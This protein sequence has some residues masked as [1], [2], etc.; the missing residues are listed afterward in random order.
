MSGR[1]DA[2]EQGSMLPGIGGGSLARV[3]QLPFGMALVTAL[4]TAVI[5][6]PSHRAAPAPTHLAM[7]AQQQIEHCYSPTREVWLTFDDG[8][9][10]KQVN[11]NLDVLERERVRAIFFPIGSW[12]AH[13]HRLLRRMVGD[14]HLVGNH[15]HDHVDLARTGSAEGLWEIRH[16][17]PPGVASAH[18]LRPPFGAGAYTARVQRMAAQSGDRLCTWTVDTRDWTGS[19]AA[20]IIR[21]VSDGDAVTPRVKA[22]GVVIMHMNGDHTGQAL[23][24]VIR[25]VRQRRLALHRLPGAGA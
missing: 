5:P 21:R 17:E 6:A 23:P 15:T 20:T 10:P 16:G 25:A 12:S 3:R 8:G 9:S 24:G 4:V 19:S 1:V 11:H 13:N 7:P 14:G 22:G 18:L 2:H